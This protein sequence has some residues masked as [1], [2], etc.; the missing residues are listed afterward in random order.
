MSEYTLGDDISI[1]SE[2]HSQG[3]SSHDENG[4]LYNVKT[5]PSDEFNT[6]NNV[7]YNVKCS[8]R[9]SAL[10]NDEQ[11]SHRN[12]ALK[13]WA[14]KNV[15]KNERKDMYGCRAPTRDNHVTHY[16]N[17]NNTACNYTH[18]TNRM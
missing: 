1:K 10:L 2:P 3:N 16:G 14:D 17:T 18:H 15:V 5:D 4:D 13:R 8:N 9:F 11:D 6:V 12:N 7:T